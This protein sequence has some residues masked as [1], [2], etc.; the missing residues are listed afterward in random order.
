MR[1]APQRPGGVQRER[2]PYPGARATRLPQVSG[3]HYVRVADTTLEWQT[4]RQSGR[5]YVRVAETTS[6]W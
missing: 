2:L 5:H 4:L 3:R 6:E 1:G